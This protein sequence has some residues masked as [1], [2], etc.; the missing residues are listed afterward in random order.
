MLDILKDKDQYGIMK[1]FNMSFDYSVDRYYQCDTEQTSL[2]NSI[3]ELLESERIS[4]NSCTIAPL[5]EFI[6][7]LTTF[8]AK[9]KA[10]YMEYYNK[11]HN[12]DQ[13]KKVRSSTKCMEL[14][15][16]IESNFQPK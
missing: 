10:I 9:A 7:Y 16:F 2:L 6:L 14:I 15:Y 1:I 11:F 12:L 13:L 3:S 5:M 8:N 4:K